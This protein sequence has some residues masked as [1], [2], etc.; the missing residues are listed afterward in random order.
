MKGIQY[1][2]NGSILKGIN[3]AI[4][5]LLPDY[6]KKEEQLLETN[7]TIFIKFDCNFFEIPNLEY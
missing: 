2:P 7:K 3:L 1:S 6:S 5:P 4:S